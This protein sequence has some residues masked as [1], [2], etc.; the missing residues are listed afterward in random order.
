MSGHHIQG[1]PLIAALRE[2]RTQDVSPVRAQRLRAQCHRA[3]NRLET[4]RKRPSTP[5]PGIWI[6]VT[7]ALAGAWSLVYFLETIRLAAAVFGF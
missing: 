4:E 2:L 3:L 6:R 5:T 1:D 7:G